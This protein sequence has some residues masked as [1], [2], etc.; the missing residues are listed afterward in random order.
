MLCLLLIQL[1]FVCVQVLLGHV[2]GSPSLVHPAEMEQR[3]DLPLVQLVGKLGGVVQAEGVLN[4]LEAGL[5][6]AEVEMAR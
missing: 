6:V 5:E 4:V 2:E 3:L 1:V